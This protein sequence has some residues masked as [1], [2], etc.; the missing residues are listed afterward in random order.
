MKAISIIVPLFNEE[1]NAGELHK[2]IVTVCRKKKYKFEIIFIDDGSTDK[3]CEISK[4]LSPIKYIQLRRNFGQTA[5]MDA[6]IKAA[7]YGYIVTM[8]GDRQN[9]PEDIPLLI[10]HLEKN[11]LDIVSGWRKKRKDPFL[12]KIISRGANLIRKV[13]INDGI[14]DSGCSLKLYKKECFD[15]VTLYGEMH[16]FIPA[17]LKIKGYRI[18]EVV[19]NH[20]PRIAGRTKYNWRRMFRG[21]I[22][23]VSVWFWNKFA[24]R[25]LHLLGGLGGFSIFLGFVSSGMTLFF[26]FINQDLSNT[27]W[28]LLTVFFFL[29]GIQLFI[30][31]LIAD[32]LSKTYFGSSP[33]TPYDIKE[34]FEKTGME[35]KK[36]KNRGKL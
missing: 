15:K 13:L 30:S 16:R 27:V 9:N 10:E 29:I 2:E 14:H 12:K 20:R 25:P 32:M 31:G 6:G 35:K 4:K 28:P 33:D 26:F 17:L 36:K 8:D 5:A 22:D 11:N 19:V 1:G 21:F 34:I 3:T 24:V 23:M 7:K 18:G